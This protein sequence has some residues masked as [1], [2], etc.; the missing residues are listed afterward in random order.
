MP[1]LWTRI[2]NFVQDFKK[3]SLMNIIVY[4]TAIHSDI[5]VNYNYLDFP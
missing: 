2:G 3:E 5:E 1:D 4:P